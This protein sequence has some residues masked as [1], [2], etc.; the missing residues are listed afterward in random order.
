M[1]NYPDCDHDWDI[2]GHKEKRLFCSKCNMHY[3]TAKWILSLQKELA[4]EK[5]E[6]AEDERVYANSIIEIQTLRKQIEEIN[7]EH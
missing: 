7:N 2:S 6:H 4:I 1:S 3:D 5:E